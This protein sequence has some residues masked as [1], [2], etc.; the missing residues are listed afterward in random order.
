M[1]QVFNDILP[2]KQKNGGGGGLFEKKFAIAAPC[3]LQSPAL[4]DLETHSQKSV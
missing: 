3:R 1:R 2:I 4:E